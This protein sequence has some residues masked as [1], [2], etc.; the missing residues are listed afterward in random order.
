MRLKIMKVLYVILSVLIMT[1]LVSCFP[2][3]EDLEA[4]E[5][6][7]IQKYLDDNPSV[8][9]D[10]KSSGLYYHEIQAGTGGMPVTH[11]TVYVFYTG[12]FLNGKLIETN[13]GTKDTL[14]A[15]LNEGLLIKALDEGISYM[16][17]GGNSLLLAPSGLAYGTTG[18]YYSVPGFTPI[19]F[20]IQLVKVK[21]GPGRK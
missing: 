21:P 6:A 16:K 5:A 20:E 15:A 18:N 9:F 12:K 11:D 14:I 10:L 2:K 17:E 7:Q 19:L 3:V 8:Q 1:L 13:V 4:E